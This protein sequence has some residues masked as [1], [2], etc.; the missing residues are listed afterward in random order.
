MRELT[1]IV[2]AFEELTAAGQSAALATVAAI[3]GSSYRR[4]GARMLVAGDGRSWGGVSGGCLERDIIRRARLLIDGTSTPIVCCYETGDDGDAKSGDTLDDAVE[5]SFLGSSTDATGD[6]SEVAKEISPIRDPGPSLGCGGQIEILIEPVSA[7]N[8]GPL[9]A[10]SA[11]VRR[12]QFAAMATVIRAS[13]RDLP[14]KRVIRIG[15]PGA[16]VKSEVVGNIDDS[17]LG[18]A[19]LRQLNDDAEILPGLLRVSLSGGEWADVLIEHVHPPQALAIFGDGQDV[20]PLVDSAK[21]LGWHVSVVGTRAVAGLR[22][23]FPNADKLICAAADDPTGGIVPLPENTAAVVMAH[24]LNRDSQVVGA[25]LKNP[26][27]YLGIL[28]PLRRTARLLAAGGGAP[29]STAGSATPPVTPSI[30]WLFAPIGLDIGAET[31]EQIALSVVAEIHAFLANRRGGFLRD[32]SGPIH[33]QSRISPVDTS[34]IKVLGTCE[35]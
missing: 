27:V 16:A 25:L 10:M 13:A 32:R 20:S 6:S 34:H 31:P 12:R 29:K 21:S 9:A 24:N 35:I 1:D 7:K 18:D 22:Q 8:P 30:P 14:G 11:A 3:S 26:P 5:D 17:A 28:G 19:M 33:F 2:A 4:P 15:N 23:R